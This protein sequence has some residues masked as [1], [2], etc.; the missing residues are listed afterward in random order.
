MA[1]AI[2]PYTEEWIPAVQALNQRLAAG[3]I[4]PEF[5][6]PDRHAPQWL[7]KLDGRRIYQEYFLATDGGAVRGGY[8]LK[9][10][11]FSFRGEMR[12][13]GFYR[14][15]LSEGIVNKTYAAVGVHLLRHAVGTQPLL[16]ALGMGGFQNPLPQMLKAMAWSLQAVPFHF[17]VAR[18]VRF[19][20]NIAPLR[21]SP[22]RRLVADLAAFTG[23]GWLGIH[24]VQRFRSH[25]IE[26]LHCE[27][28]PSF[29]DWAEEVWRDCQSSYAL[30]GC[31]DREN[32]NI[33]YPSDKNFIRVKVER[34]GQVLG[35]AT[36]LDTQM[37]DNKYFGDMRV[38]S[39]AD[40][41]SRPEN[42]LAVTQAVTAFLLDRG[43]DL[44]VSNQSHAAWGAALR[45]NGFFSGPSNFIFAAGKPLAGL[46]APLESV[47]PELHVNRGDGDGPV[48]L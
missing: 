37:R 35:W 43:V 19:L 4:A 29:G 46:L 40:C 9:F 2:Q 38:G 39:I 27:P 5:H 14:L 33:L 1:I 32:L 6:F 20:R 15:P 31:R 13:V 30:L 16:F 42:A 45:K 18:P 12:R 8:I 25:G 34:S 3:G 28:V 47:F 22:A 10:Q 24:A 26:G 36:L 23:A 48:N 11:D 7:P 17:R 41:L 44:I 21:Q